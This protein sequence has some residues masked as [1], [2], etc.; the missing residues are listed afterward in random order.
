MSLGK[1]VLDYAAYL[2]VRSAVCVLQ[3]VP[4]EACQRLARH[5]AWLLWHVM[6]LRRTVV[7]ENLAIAFPAANSVQRTAIA[8]GMWEHLLVMLAEIAHAPRK[9]HRTNWRDYSRIPDLAIMARRML[10]RRPLVI[11]SGHLGNFEMG[12]YLLG[13]HGFPTHT[14]ARPIDNPFVDRWINS[15]RGATGQYMLQKAGSGQRIAELLTAG[16]TL[17]LLGDQHAGD[18]ASWVEFFGRPAS[19][20][21]AVA[22]FTLGSEAPTAVCAALRTGRPLCFELAVADLVDPAAPAFSHRGVPE[23]LRWYSAGLER[24]IRRAPDQYWWVHRRWKGT[25]PARRRRQAEPV[26]A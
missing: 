12:G 5:G 22:L 2:A 19:T 10:D 26:A 24:L 23:M 8:L 9:L 18:G 16:E 25:P 1:T 4:I 21:K 6:R 7:E 20:H 15:F 11:L 13:L 14:I 17:A 3:A